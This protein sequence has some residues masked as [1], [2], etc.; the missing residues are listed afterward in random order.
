MAVTEIEVLDAAPTLDELAEIITA[1]QARIQQAVVGLLR[2]AFVVGDALLAVKEQLRGSFKGWL[3]GTVGM[4]R[5]TAYLYLRLAY[6]KDE[7]CAE[8]ETPS[9]EQ[10]AVFVRG[11]P[12]IAGRGS[13]HVAERA[14]AQ[15]R[16]LLALGLPQQEVAGIVGVSPGTVWRWAN[17]EAAREQDKRNQQRQSE[18]RKRERE[19]RR[20]ADIRRALRKVGAAEQEL[21]AMSERM[22][23]V[24]GKAHGEATGREKREHYALAGAH[25]RKMRDE[26][27]RALGV[28]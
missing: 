1:G 11:L 16:R 24:M 10:A 8:L 26:I 5:S 22:Q 18:R 17:P 23:D 20:A 3:E 7:I 14:R 13:G 2:D 25:Y 27:V 19:E 21:Y 9:I 12:D 15:G 28:S 6:Y 4:S